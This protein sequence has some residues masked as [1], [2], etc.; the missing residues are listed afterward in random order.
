[1]AASLKSVWFDNTFNANDGMFRPSQRD[2]LTNSAVTEL[3]IAPILKIRSI[4]VDFSYWP[5]R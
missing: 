1:M 4:K 2:M 3:N 5:F